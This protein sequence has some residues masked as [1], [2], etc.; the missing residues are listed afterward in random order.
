[1]WPRHYCFPLCHTV[2]EPHDFISAR[3]SSVL[4]DEMHS[5]FSLR[6]KLCVLVFL[7]NQTM[8]S[9]PFSKFIRMQLFGNEDNE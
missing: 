1:M 8:S 2:A 9:F 7:N 4:S 3:V 6:R 5:A